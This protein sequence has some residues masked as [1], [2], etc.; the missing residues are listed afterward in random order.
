MSWIL[1][2]SAAYATLPALG[3]REPVSGLT[4]L[5]AGIVSLFG[6]SVLWDRSRGDRPKQI[7]MLIYGGSL[8]ALSYNDGFLSYASYDINAGDFG[9][10]QMNFG[11]F[12]GTAIPEPSTC[13]AL[14]ALGAGLAVALKR[15]RQ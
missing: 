8:V 5:F 13:A 14:A 9:A 2:L 6:A 15:R 10:S 1:P 7:S 3:L 12:T 4:H 11:T